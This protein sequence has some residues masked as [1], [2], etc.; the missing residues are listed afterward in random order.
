MSAASYGKFVR[1][2]LEHMARTLPGPVVREWWVKAVDQLIAPHVRDR[3]YDREVPIDAVPADLWSL[4]GEI[5]PPFEIPRRETM[6]QGEQGQRL[7]P[8]GKVAGR[9]PVHAGCHGKVRRLKQAARLSINAKRRSDPGA[10]ATPR[11]Q[12]VNLATLNSRGSGASLMI[13][14]RSRTI[15]RDLCNQR[16]ESAAT[17]YHDQHR[18]DRL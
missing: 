9:S 17:P 14:W 18:D 8:A 16:H 4:Q 15:Y 10:A 7:W 1:L 5:P 13:S 3:G 6:G 2:K 11:Q 12:K